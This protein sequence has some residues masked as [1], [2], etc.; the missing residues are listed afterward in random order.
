METKTETKTDA[1][2]TITQFIQRKSSKRDQTGFGYM[3]LKIELK[4]KAK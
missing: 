1:K 2:Q 3:S 4:E